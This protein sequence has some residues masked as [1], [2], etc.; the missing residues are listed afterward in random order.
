M[1]GG[2]EW[3]AA[4]RVSEVEPQEDD[5]WW[6]MFFRPSRRK[7]EGW[8]S[9]FWK[10]HFVLTLLPCLVVWLWVAMPFPVNDPYK[11]SPLPDIPSWPKKPKGSD[12]DPGGGGD[13]SD[14][15]LPLDVNFYFFLF[16]YFG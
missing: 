11:D 3:R 1:W 9:S 5:T 2:R 4:R 7:V 14:E 6:Q 15:V 8:L 13:G 16:W 12:A 10:R